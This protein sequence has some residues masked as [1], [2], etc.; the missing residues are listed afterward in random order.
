M[1]HPS[2]GSSA[3]KLTI[4]LSPDHRRV[5]RTHPGGTFPHNTRVQLIMHIKAIKAFE[6]IRRQFSIWVGYVEM[7][8]K[9]DAS[10]LWLPSIGYVIAFGK[11]SDLKCSYTSHSGCTSHLPTIFIHHIVPYGT[12]ELRI[13]FWGPN[14][15]RAYYLHTIS[16][17]KQQ[18][19]KTS[20]VSLRDI[21]I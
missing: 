14:R 6:S 2:L 7:R 15:S 21:K 11:P 5:S 18:R 12:T 3:R 17:P 10:Q 4:S 16:I 8:W 19:Y 20:L 13:P 9:V 1:R